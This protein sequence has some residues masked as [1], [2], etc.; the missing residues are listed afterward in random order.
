MPRLKNYHH[1]ID[2]SPGNSLNNTFWQ[3]QTTVGGPLEV[4]LGF[5]RNKTGASLGKQTG[6]RHPFIFS[7]SVSTA[8]V[9]PE[10]LT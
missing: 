7:V 4:V 10:L 6:K 3:A 5:I 9:L 2:I 8:M 1:S